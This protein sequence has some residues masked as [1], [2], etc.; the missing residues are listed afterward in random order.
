MVVSCA[1]VPAPPTLRSVECSAGT[2]LLSWKTGGEHNAAITAF[3]AHATDNITNAWHLA[4]EQMDQ[5]QLTAEVRRLTSVHS[6][7]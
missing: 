3:H 6:D 7:S 1:D 2:A 5:D 4:L